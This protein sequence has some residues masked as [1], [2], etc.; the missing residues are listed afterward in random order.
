MKIKR[1]FILT[2]R[3]FIFINR[4]FIFAVCCLAVLVYFERNDKSQFCTIVL[5]QL[6]MKLSGWN[7]KPYNGLLLWIIFGKLRPVW[8]LKYCD[9]A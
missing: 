1:R 3:R 2:K 4:R 5:P 6:V 7:C 8:Y 9:F